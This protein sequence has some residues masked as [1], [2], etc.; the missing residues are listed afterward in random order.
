MMQKDIKRLSLILLFAPFALWIVLL[1]ILPHLGMFYMSLREKVGPR[2]Y[3]FGLR[4]T[5]SISSPNRSTG[6]R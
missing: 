4:A 5:T 6:T 3:E 1:I 2:M